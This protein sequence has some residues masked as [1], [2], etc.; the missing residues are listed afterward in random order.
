MKGRVGYNSKY[1]WISSLT[2]ETNLRSFGPYGKEDQAYAPFELPAM[3]GKI[4]G[5]HALAGDYLYAVGVY[6]QVCKII[7][8]DIKFHHFF[9]RRY[10]RGLVGKGHSN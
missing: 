8:V 2:F 10:E 1:L 4:I 9:Q 3:R 5:F 6:V 7:I